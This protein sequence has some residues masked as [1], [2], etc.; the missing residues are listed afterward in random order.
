MRRA[1]VRHG[2]AVQ[3]VTVDDGGRLHTVDGRVL[4]KTK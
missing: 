2:S 4:V 1:R 3:D